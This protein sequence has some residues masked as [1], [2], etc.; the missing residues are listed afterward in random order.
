MLKDYFSFIFTPKWNFIKTHWPLLCPCRKSAGV[1]LH[2]SWYLTTEDIRRTRCKHLAGGAGQESSS[3]VQSVSERYRHSTLK[4]VHYIFHFNP[5]YFRWMSAAGR[6]T[7]PSPDPSA[8]HPEKE[9]E[10]KGAEPQ[11]PA[12]VNHHGGGHIVRS[13]LDV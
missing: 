6:I 9:R 13:K 4:P 1:F 8:F 10:N 2:A 3:V 7:S 11:R 12:A 5:D